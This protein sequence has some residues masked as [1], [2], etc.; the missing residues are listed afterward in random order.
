MA[1]GIN[2][3]VIELDPTV[4]KFATRYFGFPSPHNV[5]IQDAI[6][7]VEKF[8]ATEEDR[9]TYDY[10]VHDVFTG[11]A[12][13]VQ[14]FTQEFL[15]G[16]SDMLNADGVIAIVSAVHEFSLIGE[17]TDNVRIMLVIYSVR[18]PATLSAPSSRFFQHVGCTERTP[19]L[20]VRPLTGVRNWQGISP[21]WSSF[22]ASRA[23]ISLSDG[24]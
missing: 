10:I 20:P 1:H 5:I 2:T 4:Y 21:T 19:I 17:D 9:M 14:L 15:Q 16:L 11:G 12:E 6:T 22:A 3:T 23:V 8:K 24:Q 18:Q 13:P 7:F